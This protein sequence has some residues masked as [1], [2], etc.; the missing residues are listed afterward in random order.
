[1]GSFLKFPEQ[2]YWGAA[3]AAYQI[4]GAIQ[5]DGRGESIWDRFANTPGKVRNGDTGAVA[6]DHYHRYEDDVQMIDAMGLNAYRFSISWPRVLPEGYGQ[7][8]PKGLDFYS[9]L[10]D[11]LLEK[12]I[13]PFATLFHWDLPTALQD[14]GGWVNRRI[15][16]W[17]TEYADRMY[18]TLGDR[19]RYW[20]T[21]NEPN[22][23][24]F[25]GY[26]IGKHAPGVQDLS[27]YLQVCHHLLLA[28]GEAVTRGRERLQS[29]KFGIVPAI[30]HNYPASDSA[31]D[32]AMVE[33]MW[34]YG[35]QQFLDPL[36]RGAYP[37]SPVPEGLRLPVILPGDMEKIAVP[38]DY[39]GINH[40][41]SNWLTKGSDGEPQWVKKDLPT[42]DRGWNIYPDGFRDM[43][44]KVTEEYGRIPIYIMENGASYPDQVSPD[45]GVHDSERVAYFQGY[46]RALHEAIQQGVDVKGYFAW[47][48]MDNFEWEEGYASRFGIVHVDFKTQKRTVKDSGHFIT[49]VAKD[50]GLM[51]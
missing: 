16:D 46:L 37:E 28:H 30:A 10:V 9:R 41:F 5:E 1:M 7:A 4:E 45:G 20:A 13:E 31:E 11:R 35:T 14:A 6:C 17:F 49:Q 48:L 38:I 39:L 40:Y 3:T 15:V 27:T 29:A 34:K 33:L 51:G 21:V 43:L 47:S 18:Q 12:G 22:V 19:V 42:T 24:S 44:L 2:F 23:F 32:H 8:N 26:H 25:L 50:N 36:F